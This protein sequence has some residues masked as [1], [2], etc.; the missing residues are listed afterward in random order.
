MSKTRM[1][2]DV[3]WKA[4]NYWLEEE[5]ASCCAAYAA[6]HGEPWYHIQSSWDSAAKKS[7]AVQ[8]LKQLGCPVGGRKTFASFE[9]GEQRQ[10]VRH[11]WLLL[12][13]HVAEDE[14]IEIGG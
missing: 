4:A 11:T 3:L 5:I 12:A 13:M 9:A 7:A 2:A 6:E 14:G 8:F 1:L 10:G